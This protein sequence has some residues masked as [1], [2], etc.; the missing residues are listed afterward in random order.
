MN[1]PVIA[2][3]GFAASG[4]GTLARN[5][6]KKLGFAW[7]DTGALYRAVALKVIESG[8]DPADEDAATAA[9]H[10]LR[11]NLDPKELDSPILRSDSVGDGASKVAT[12]AGVRSALLQYQ[13]DFAAHPPE[14]A[15]GAVLD[16]RD[17]GTVICPTATVKFF[18]TASPETRAGR[19]F[20]ELQSR[21]LDATYEAVLEEMRTRDARDEGRAEAPLKPASDAKTIDTTSMS[22]Q[23]V[24]DIALSYVR[25]KLL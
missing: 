15:K 8:A 22:E 16:G 11:E 3:D 14:T 18:I 2:I 1:T 10:A 4:K 13:K 21:G 19:R 25:E 17:I 6:A 23:D 12:Y 9:A 7:L 20:K 24:L 5:L